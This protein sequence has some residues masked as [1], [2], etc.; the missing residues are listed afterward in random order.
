MTLIAAG[1]GAL[2]GKGGPQRMFTFS[3]FAL[4]TL[5]PL[6]WWVKMQGLGPATQRK[7]ANIF[8]EDG[9]TKEEVARFQAMDEIE[10]LAHNMHARPGYGYE[11]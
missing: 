11:R 7:P 4:T 3:F 8:Y 10:N 9:V 2:T 5:A 6:T 1:A